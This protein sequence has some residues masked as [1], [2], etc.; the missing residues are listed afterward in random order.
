MSLI[1]NNALVL[2][3]L[4]LKGGLFIWFCFLIRFQIC[5]DL[6]VN[7]L[8]V[9][10]YN[11]WAFRV[12][13]F[14]LSWLNLDGLTRQSLWCLLMLKVG[15][16]AVLRGEGSHNTFVFTIWFHSRT[17]VCWVLHIVCFGFLDHFC[18]IWNICIF[19]WDYN[20]VWLS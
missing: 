4:E 1:C 14:S 12:A 5:R 16:F 17:Q 11:A 2:N 7:S 13:L 8:W 3:L 6:Q 19:I 18:C 20:I 10:I 15:S 9:C